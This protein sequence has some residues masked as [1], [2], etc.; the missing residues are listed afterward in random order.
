MR[1]PTSRGRLRQVL[2]VSFG[3][4]VLVGNTILI[5]ILRTPGDVAAG[6]PS[7]PLFIGV[8][9]IGGLFAL[10]GAISLA[11]PGAMLARSGGQYVP[12]YPF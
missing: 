6:L 7:P 4:A 10:L 1:P 3:V 8:W 11:E 5:G 12:G 2:G 9:I